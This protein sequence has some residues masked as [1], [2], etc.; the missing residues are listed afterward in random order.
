MKYSLLI[1]IS[2]RQKVLLIRCLHPF[3]NGTET[4][5][6]CLHGAIFFFWEANRSVASPEILRFVWNPMAVHCGYKNQTLPLS[7]T[8][9][10]QAMNFH[11]YVFKMH[12]SVLSHLR[13]VLPS[14]LFSVGFLIITVYAHHPLPH[15]CHIFL[16]SRSDWSPEEYLVRTADEAF[17]Y[18]SSP[19]PLLPRRS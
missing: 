1:I 10:V 2:G 15:M 16:P 14:N 19:T 7:W 6:N 11:S 18:A 17:H 13:V 4:R 5:N 8:I 3:K 12:L 9:L